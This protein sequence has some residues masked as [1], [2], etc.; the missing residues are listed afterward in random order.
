MRLCVDCTY[1][2]EVEFISTCLHILRSGMLK[3]TKREPVGRSNEETILV[4]KIWYF[5][6]TCIDCLHWKRKKGPT[7]WNFTHNTLPSHRIFAVFCSVRSLPP[8][9]P[10]VYWHND[11]PRRFHYQQHATRHATRSG[12]ATTFFGDSA[13]EEGAQNLLRFTSYAGMIAH[14][15]EHLGTTGGPSMRNVGNGSGAAGVSTLF[16]S[17]TVSFSFR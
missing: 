5:K 3:Y 8:R 15:T 12:P 4:H 10:C 6:S 9:C 11:P 16:T 2:I 7:M 13:H 17:I 1:T 14:A